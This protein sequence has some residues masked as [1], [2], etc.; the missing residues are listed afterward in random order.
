MGLTIREIEQ[1]R[2]RIAPYITETPLLRLPQLD[3]A[4]GCRVYAKAECMQT[5][6]SFKLRGAMNRLLTLGE[7]ALSRGIVAASS[8]NHGK[9]VAY[10]ARQLHVKATVVLPYTAAKVKVE[11]IRAWGA[12]IVQCDVAERFEVAERLSRER[13]AAY[14][15]PFNDEAVMAGQGTAGVELMAQCPELD[16]VV[17]PVSGGGLIGG[18]ATA[19]K[20]VSPGTRVYGAEPAAL[21]RYTAS[22]AAG[23]PVAVEKRPTVADGL[24]SNQ[25]GDVCFPYVARYTDGFA[26]VTEEDILRGMKLLLLEGKLLA[27]PSSAVGIGAALAGQLP[28]SGEDRV[29]FFISGGSVALEQLRMLEDVP[30]PHL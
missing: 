18:V 25:P 9:A 10:A 20:A 3:T 1:A 12:E 30:V 22:L 2:A 11:T 5:T 24:V 23:R 17:L 8:G 26:D 21:P 28:L 15:P 27:E 4:L 6:G 19:V 13:G 7:E 16:A 14:V 29:C